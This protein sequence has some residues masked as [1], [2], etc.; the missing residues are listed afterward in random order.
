MKCIYYVTQYL[1]HHS[2]FFP[3][4]LIHP[5]MPLTHAQ[6]RLR[7]DVRTTPV[8]RK[9]RVHELIKELGLS[10]VQHSRIGSPESEKSLSGGE[11]KRL[12]FATEV[13]RGW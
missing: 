2:V 10:K 13:R 8:D 3:H 6:A 1:S 11:R 5:S 7:M 4:S 9:T 12:A